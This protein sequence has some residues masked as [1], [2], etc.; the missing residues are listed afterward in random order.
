MCGTEIRI[1]LPLAT[2]E[3]SGCGCCSPA[4]RTQTPTPDEGAEYLVEGLTC[5]HCVQTVEKA[6][7][8]VPGVESATVELVVGGM[9]RLTVAGE[10][11]GSAV[12]D[13]VTGAGYSVTALK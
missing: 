2:A 3:S 4:A 8:A 13:A 6:V 1:D 10:V 5:G 7:S 12:W 9:S 11:G